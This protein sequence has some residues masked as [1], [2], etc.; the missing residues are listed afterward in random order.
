MRV[1]VVRIVLITTIAIVIIIV[2]VNQRA[3]RCIHKS[4]DKGLD[5]IEIPDD[6]PKVCRHRGSGQGHRGADICRFRASPAL[7]FFHDS[8]VGV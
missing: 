8:A 2:N 3:N 6:R 4:T 7:H 1:T 5:G